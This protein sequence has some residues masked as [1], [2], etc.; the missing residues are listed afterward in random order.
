MSW[1]DFML[2]SKHPIDFLTGSLRTNKYVKMPTKIFQTLLEKFKR[3][4][5]E[6]LRLFY[7]DIR[8]LSYEV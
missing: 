2:F 7:H 6:L 5:K 3:L 1:N 8:K 4:V